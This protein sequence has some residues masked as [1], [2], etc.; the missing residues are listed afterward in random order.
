MLKGKI[1]STPT[2]PGRDYYVKVGSVSVDITDDVRAMIASAV[3]QTCAE[4]ERTIADLR[5]KHADVADRYSQIQRIVLAGG[6]GM[7]TG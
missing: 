6:T 7:P 1:I 4:Y 2:S 5:A 3:E